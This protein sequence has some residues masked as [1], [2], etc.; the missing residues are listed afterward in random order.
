VSSGGADE[1]VDL[2]AGAVEGGLVPS[3]LTGSLRGYQVALDEFDEAVAR[4]LGVNRTDLRCLDLLSSHQPMTAGALARA[5][6]L[7][8]GAITFVLDRLEQAGF[9]RRH[10]DPRDRRKVVI[11][12][13]AEAH[14]R[15]FMLYWPLVAEMRAEAKGFSASD[16][17]AIGRFF[18]IG[19]ELYRRHARLLRGE[20]EVESPGDLAE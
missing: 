4:C 2:S 11:E 16:L 6:G 14:R 17:E 18:V 8:S 7:S 20:P 13:V 5:A 15:A 12:L 9:V 1:R 10:R 3:A 19:R